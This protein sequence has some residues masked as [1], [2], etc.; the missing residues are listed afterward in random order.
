[1]YGVGDELAHVDGVES[2]KMA[3]LT[4]PGLVWTR[5]VPFSG[6]TALEA[7]VFGAVLVELSEKSTFSS[8]G[9]KLATF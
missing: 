9:E 2:F 4:V 6:L 5:V 7:W 1:M 8:F 3:S